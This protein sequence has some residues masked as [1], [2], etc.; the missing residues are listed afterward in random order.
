VMEQIRAEVSLADL[1]RPEGIPPTI[2]YNWLKVLMEARRARLY[3]DAKREATSN[4][5]Q[6]LWPESGWLKLLVAEFS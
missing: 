6:C 2:Y 1:C 5:V 4:R 3:A